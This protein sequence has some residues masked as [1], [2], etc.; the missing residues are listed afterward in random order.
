MCSKKIDTKIATK[1]ITTIGLLI[2]LAGAQSCGAAD[3]ERYK[4]LK[5]QEQYKKL[6]ATITADD[7]K[8]LQKLIDAQA[9]INVTDGGAG[10]R[11][12]INP[13]SSIRSF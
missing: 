1:T 9:D 4:K 8:E 3:S 10:R 11:Y 5:N 6:R 7:R 12:R 13:R 2:A